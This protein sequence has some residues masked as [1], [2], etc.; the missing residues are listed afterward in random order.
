MVRLVLALS[1]PSAGRRLTRGARA[2]IK[3]PMDLATL[4]KKVKQQ[5]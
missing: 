3:R 4:L 1:I 2:V 5:S